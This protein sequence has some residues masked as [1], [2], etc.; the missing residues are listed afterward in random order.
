MVC[1]HFIIYVC[2]LVIPMGMSSLV[3]AGFLI[4]GVLYVIQP[5]NIQGLVVRFIMCSPI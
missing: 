3:G 2:I 4:Y 5:I 1:Y